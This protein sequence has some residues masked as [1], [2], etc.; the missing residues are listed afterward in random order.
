MKD[1]PM[2]KMLYVTTVFEDEND[3]IWKKIKY[4][5]YAYQRL[6]F[7]IDFAYRTKSG[8]VI[9]YNFN[10]SDSRLVSIDEPHKDLFFYC[11]AKK[12]KPVYN[13]LYIRKPFGGASF[14]FLNALI[15]KLSKSNCRVALEIPTYP[16]KKEIKQ[17]K[18]IISEYLF[19][20][21]K[22]LY[23]NKVDLIVFMGAYVEN[24]WNRPA[25]RIANGIDLDKVPPLIT[26]KNTLNNE[27]VFVGV[28]RLSF[29]HGYDRLINAISKYQGNYK[30]KFY[31]IGEGEDES[32][33]LKKIVQ[34]LN[35]SSNVVFQGG[36]YGQELDKQYC[37]A[38]VCIDS[39]G[40]HRS[41]NLYNS[42]LKSKEYTAKGLPFIK[43]HKDDS[44]ENNFF[45]F[46][47]NPDE[48]DIEIGEIIEWYKS[49]PEE[50]PGMMRDF[51]ENSLS[52]DIQ[53]KKV[54]DKLFS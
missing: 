33:R 52:W 27:F 16:Y 44:F 37:K 29:W 28:A 31:I 12:I 51:A 9:N 42:S 49:L 23:I 14:I 45:I 46:N 4:T 8:Y 1:N 43:S 39:L 36:L 21:S 38:H 24:I 18:H 11:L 48:S 15:R 10:E 50:T 17:L 6:G 3:G 53:C 22:L 47:V 34:S 32:S 20:F 41:G 54:L 13:F 19:Q 2:K 25:L 7:S 26:R 35:L 30:I 5:L 40:R